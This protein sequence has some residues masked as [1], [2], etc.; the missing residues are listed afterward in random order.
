MTQF[1]ELLTDIGYL[2]LAVLTVL[3]PWRLVYLIYRTFKVRHW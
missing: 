3:A 2:A 1:K